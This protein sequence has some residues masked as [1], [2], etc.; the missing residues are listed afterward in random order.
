MPMYG[1]ALPVYGYVVTMNPKW[2]EARLVKDGRVVSE[3]FEDRFSAKAR[4]DRWVAE[5][6][7]TSTPVLRQAA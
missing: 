1:S 4:V 6:A 7:T 5:N 3:S 2:H